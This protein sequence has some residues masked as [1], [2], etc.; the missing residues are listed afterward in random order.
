LLVKLAGRPLK[1]LYG[2]TPA[3]DLGPLALEAVRQKR[4][5]AILSRK[6][7]NGSIDRLTRMF[8][9][10]VASLPLMVYRKNHQSKT[11]H[12]F[13]MSFWAYDLRKIRVPFVSSTGVANAWWEQEKRRSV[14]TS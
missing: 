9:W 3:R 14:T 5:D 1:D 2:Q 7:I 12:F 4:I 10:A 8:K 13:S 11:G 6:H